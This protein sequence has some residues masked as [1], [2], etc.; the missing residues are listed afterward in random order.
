MC[1]YQE[2]GAGVHD[3][4]QDLTNPEMKSKV[5]EL[6]E[7][8][9]ILLTGKLQE[10]A[11]LA[12][13]NV[14]FPEKALSTRIQAAVGDEVRVILVKLSYYTCVCILQVWMDME[15]EIRSTVAIHIYRESDIPNR[16]GHCN[17]NPYIPNC[18]RAKLGMELLDDGEFKRLKRARTHVA[19]R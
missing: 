1:A 3:L 8:I 10:R 6:A 12:K 14:W 18:L 2:R 15:R 5:P 11:V 13:G 19:R 4:L 16:H 17:S 9:R 7:K